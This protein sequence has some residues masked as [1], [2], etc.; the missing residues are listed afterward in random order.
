M[1]KNQNCDRTQDCSIREYLGEKHTSYPTFM[2]RAPSRIDLAGGTTDLKIFCEDEEVL[3]DPERPHG[4]TLNAAINLEA[5]VD[6]F[7]VGGKGLYVQSYTPHNKFCLYLQSLDD[8]KKMDGRDEEEEKEAKKNG[9]EY[10]KPKDLLL[11]ALIKQAGFVPQGFVIET[12]AKAPSGSGLGSSAAMGVTFLKSLYEVQGINVSLSQIA[13]QAAQAEW[14]LSIVGGKQ[15]QY[16]AAFGGLNLWEFRQEKTDPKPIDFNRLNY[17]RDKLILCYIHDED[18]ISGDMNEEVQ[19]AFLSGDPVVRRSLFR[20]RD[21][22]E[23]MKN[24]LKNEDYTRFVELLNEETEN[25]VKLHSSVA[26]P[27]VLN[28]IDVARNSG[29]NAAKILG[30]GGKGSLLFYAENGEKEN[31]VKAIEGF[32]ELDCEILPFEFGQEGLTIRKRNILE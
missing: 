9:E 32:S 15:D 22:A 29:A 24:A 11:R 6:V 5:M 20:L 13:E 30:A 27:E 26:P 31:L 8:L 17:L 10:K 21:I 14:S 23:D 1:I 2:I 19:N 4:S 25:R 18:R 7:N 3:Q 12:Y 28:L 16:A